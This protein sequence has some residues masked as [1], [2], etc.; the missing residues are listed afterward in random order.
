MNTDRSNH[1]YLSADSTRRQLL[2]KM[3]RLFLLLL[4][5]GVSGMLFWRSRC[6]TG[7]EASYSKLPCGNCGRLSGCARPSAAVYRN[8]NTSSRSDKDA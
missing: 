3:G 4:T 5:A 8:M 2:L 1:N 7:A 6:W